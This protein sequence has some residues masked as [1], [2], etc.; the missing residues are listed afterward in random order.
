VHNPDH[1]RA[2][3][4]GYVYEHILVAESVLGHSLPA[5]A[6]VHH[7]DGNKH[8]NAPGNLVICEDDAYHRLLHTRMRRLDPSRL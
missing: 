2:N 4:R 5:G 8:N 1:P 6:V 7:V 3:T